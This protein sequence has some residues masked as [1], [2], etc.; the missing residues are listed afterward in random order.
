MDLSLDLKSQVKKQQRKMGKAANGAS[1]KDES[2]QDTP[3]MRLEECL[4]RFTHEEKLAKEDYRCVKCERQRDAV[5]QLSVRKCP[6][7]L[8]VHLKVCFFF[9][10]LPT[11]PVYYRGSFLA[12]LCWVEGFDTHFMQRFSHTKDKSSKLEMPVTFPVELD[13]VPYTTWHQNSGPGSTSTTNGAAAASRS[14][15]SSAEAMYL[16]SAVIV[17]KGEINSGHYVSYAREGKDWFLF[18]DSKVVLVG[19]QEVLGAQAYLLVYVAGKV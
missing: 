15:S 7:V 10:L 3:P 8:V 6:P 17:H 11:P 1:A 2:A 14:L 16:L 9:F 13:M 19:E 18:D 12:L 5:K 4:A